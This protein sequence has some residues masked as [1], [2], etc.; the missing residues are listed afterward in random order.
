M[1][2][3]TIGSTDY[4][5]V[6]EMPRYSVGAGW[7]VR[8]TWQGPEAGFETKI[9]ALL[10]QSPAPIGLDT[11]RNAPVCTITAT[12]ARTPTG[13]TWDETE[14]AEAEAEWRLIPFD[15]QKDLATHGAFNIYGGGG[16]SPDVVLPKIDAAIKDGT[17]GDVDWETDYDNGAAVSYYDQYAELKAI[18]VRNWLTFGFTLRK[19]LAVSDDS[20]A[21]ELIQFDQDNAGKIVTWNNATLKMPA[22]SGIEQPWAHMFIGSWQGLAGLPVKGGGAVVEDDW[23]DVL[24]DQWMVRPPR[25]GYRKVGRV[26]KRLI[27]QE[28]VGAIHWSSTL[29]DGGT[30]TP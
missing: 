29:Y 18:G 9:D 20:V 13:V 24:F 26:R 5:L 21:G 23:N 4:T 22:A 15:V 1:A 25:L 11:A 27:E 10:A 12:F 30:G 19:S 17:A 16:N 28:W 14:Q 7:T 6:S 3:V 2:S 8:E